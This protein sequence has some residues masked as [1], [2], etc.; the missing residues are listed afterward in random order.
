MK[1]TLRLIV[2]L[3]PILISAC[4]GSAG[5][6]CAWTRE[7]VPEAGFEARWTRAEKVQAAAHN[8]AWRENCAD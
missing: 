8:K 2:C 1:S 7:F 6:G 4:A 5:D 3:T